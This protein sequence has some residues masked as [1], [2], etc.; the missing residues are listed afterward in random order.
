[1]KHERSFAEMYTFFSPFLTQNLKKHGSKVKTTA[2]F[3]RTTALF[4]KTSG[5]FI[6]TMALF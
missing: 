5:L 3:P 6:K 4:L 2:M 1:M